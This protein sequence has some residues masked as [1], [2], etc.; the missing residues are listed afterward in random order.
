MFSVSNPVMLSFRAP[1]R[2]ASSF[3]TKT[4]SERNAGRCEAPPARRPLCT[5]NYAPSDADVDFRFETWVEVARGC[6]ATATSLFRLTALDALASPAP[7]TPKT[8]DRCRWRCG[9]FH[10]A[11]ARNKTS[12]VVRTVYFF[13]YLFFFHFRQHKHTDF[14]YRFSRREWSRGMARESLS[15]CWPHDRKLFAIKYDKLCTGDWGGVGMTRFGCA[16]QRDLYIGV[17]FCCLFGWVFEMC[18]GLVGS[19]NSCQI[20]AS[21]ICR[22]E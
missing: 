2:V 4:R 16:E 10:D 22:E 21:K 20:E 8:H 13:I 3:S 17:R 12:S 19:E 14:P 1:V 5:I 6:S 15:K 9:Q 7:K 18:I 11:R